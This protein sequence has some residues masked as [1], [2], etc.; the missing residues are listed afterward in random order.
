MEKRQFIKD[1]VLTSIAMPIGFGGMAK[2]FANHS[3]KSPSVLAE[4]NAFWEQIRQQY[5]L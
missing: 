4:D 2:A 3:E 1:L 5:I